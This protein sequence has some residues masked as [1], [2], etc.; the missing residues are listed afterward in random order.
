MMPVRK[1]Q[2]NHLSLL[3]GKDARSLQ[4]EMNDICYKLLPIQRNLY[5]EKK[6]PSQD[7]RRKPFSHLKI[8]TLLYHFLQ[9]IWLGILAPERTC[10]GAGRDESVRTKRY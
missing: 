10:P 2:C 3:P 4:Q 8:L 6:P 9:C 7:P 1:N 5:R